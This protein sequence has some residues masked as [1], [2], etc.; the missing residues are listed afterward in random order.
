MLKL[1]KSLFFTL[2]LV[3]FG[4]P[5]AFGH[6]P[7]SV[8]NRFIV[9]IGLSGMGFGLNS[10]GS[11]PHFSGS[12]VNTENCG[13]FPNSQ[14]IHNQI[15]AEKKLLSIS[16]KVIDKPLTIWLNVSIGD[17]NMEKIIDFW[18]AK[19]ALEIKGVM[20]RL[21]REQEERQ[22]IQQPVKKALVISAL[23]G[24]AIPPEYEDLRPFLQRDGIIL[25]SWAIWKNFD[26][27]GLVCRV[28]WV[29][30][31]RN[32]THY[33]ASIK[34]IGGVIKAYPEGRGD[35]EYSIGKYK[36]GC[37]CEI[38]DTVF[39]CAPELTALTRPFFIEKLKNT[40]VNVNFDFDFSLGLAKQLQFQKQIELIQS[41]GLKG[42]QN[43]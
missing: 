15:I 39:I 18:E 42:V 11:K 34:D 6:F 38:A 33:A 40:G 30:S 32:L 36:I 28:N 27:T 29:K 2:F 20:R 4:G 5:A 26:D 41:L 21:Q 9:N 3:F 37:I 24:E 1:K 14:T 23:P 7:D 22:K 12:R 35:Y 13:N 8:N 19:Q 31:Y 43:A 10:G 25:L 16:S 17:R